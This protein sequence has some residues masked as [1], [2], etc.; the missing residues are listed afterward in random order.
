MHRRPRVKPS[1]LAR[2]VA[3]RRRYN[4]GGAETQPV[5]GAR[6]RDRRVAAPR[7][8]QPG[9]GSRASTTPT[10]LPATRPRPGS[11]TRRM[12]EINAA[13]EELRDPVTR[14]AAADRARGGTPACHGR[15]ACARCADR[16]AAPAAADEPARP[17]LAGRHGRSPG[18]PVTARLDMTDTYAPAQPDRGT[19]GH[20]RDYG[21]ELPRHRRATAPSRAR[22]RALRIP[23]V[24]CA[25]RGSATSGRRRSRNCTTPWPSSSTSAS[26][27]ATRWARSPRSSRPT[28][29]GWP[30]RSR[31]IASSSWRRA[32]SRTTS[33][34]A[35]CHAIRPPRRNQRSLGGRRLEDVELALGHRSVGAKRIARGPVGA[36][37]AAPGRC[38]SRS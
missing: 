38:R 1:P 18:R 24:R 14:R 27:T 31:A 16:R 28:S 21:R 29:T 33:T 34:R 13:Y 20:R 9:G 3:M 25:A 19:N 2:T 32:S 30:A 4:P 23:P 12:A 10:R 7:S 5:R 22:R 15:P 26:S 11:A 37:S 6:R 8:R 17:R 35:A 36:D